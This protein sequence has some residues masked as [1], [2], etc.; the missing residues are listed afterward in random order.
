MLP[1]RYFEGLIA[2]AVAAEAE[3]NAP[4]EEGLND[5]E[6]LAVARLR[7][8]VEVFSKKYDGILDSLRV[9]EVPL[10]SFAILTPPL[11]NL[12]YKAQC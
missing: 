8:E 9:D 2:T 3:A 4:A 7:E 6:R 10:T 12:V 11:T 5:E 1:L